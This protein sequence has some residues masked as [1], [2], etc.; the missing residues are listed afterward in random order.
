MADLLFRP[1]VIEAGRQRLT[2]T[3]VAAVPPSSRIY[4]L[5]CVLVIAVGALFLAFGEYAPSVRAPG[6]I[7]YDSGLARV[8]PSAAAEIRQIHVRPGQRVEA[9]DPLVTLT[10][11]QGR[12]GLQ[13]QIDQ[14]TQQDGELARQGELAGALGSTEASGLA[15]QKAALQAMI[16]SLERQRTLAASQVGLA[17]AAVRRATRLAREGAGAQRQVE[18]SRGTLL[19]RRAELESIRERLITQSEAA[20]ALDI[21][22]QQKRLQA[23][24]SQSL[25]AAQRAALA[26]QREELSRANEI[27]LVAPVAGEVSDVAMVAGQRA[28]PERSLV[29][30]VPATSK[31]EVW[32]YAPSSALG[33]AEPGQEVRIEF[34]AFPSRRHGLGR[35][36]VLEVSRVSVEPNAVGADLGLTEPAFRIRVRIDEMPHNAERAAEALRPGMTV[37]AA[38]IQ[39]KRS[40]WEML[41]NP[42]AGVFGR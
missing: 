27:T 5:I 25:L 22:I 18:E 23:S 31:L 16:G 14:I 11:A 34:D 9:G 8:F 10:L 26:G 13:P 6:V 24:Q 36:T 21:Q 37:S 30:I 35:G 41:F 38:L 32:L 39:E 19:A 20:R 28:V 15:Q 3:V 42:V 29:T 1:E 4:T 2:G 40:L 7:A 33:Y 17:E 12:D